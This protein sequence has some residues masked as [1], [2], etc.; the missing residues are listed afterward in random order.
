MA[1]IPGTINRDTLDGL[2]ESVIIQGLDE[3]DLIRGHGGNNVIQGHEGNDDLFDGEGNDIFQGD[4]GDNTIE[5]GSG[6][7]TI[8]VE[9]GEGSD[10]VF[11]FQLDS[12]NFMR[13]NADEL[14]FEQYN[15][16]AN[17]V[18]ANTDLLASVDGTQVSTFT[19]N[20][21]T[22]FIDGY[23]LTRNARFRDDFWIEG[24][25]PDQKIRVNLNG[26][27]DPYLQLINAT[28]GEVTTYLDNLVIYGFWSKTSTDGFDGNEIDVVILDLIKN[29]QEEFH[30]KIIFSRKKITTI[31]YCLQN[32]FFLEGENSSFRSCSE[33]KNYLHLVSWY[34]YSHYEKIRLNW[35]KYFPILNLTLN[36]WIK[37][38]LSTCAYEFSINDYPGLLALQN[39]SIS[40]SFGEFEQ[41]N[42]G[43]STH[44]KIKTLPCNLRHS[45]A[46]TATAKMERE[47]SQENSKILNQLVQEYVKLSRILDPSEEEE[48]RL[49][50]ILE[51][52]ESDDELSKLIS[53][54]DH[55]IYQE[56]TLAEDDCKSK[57]NSGHTLLANT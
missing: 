44:S 17:I 52:A 15:E 56:L 28:T 5:L 11:N 14:G 41:P 3:N 32:K 23:N 4:S 46:E 13:V 38:I 9:T 25:T 7:N 20:L 33:S 47:K 35:K 45:S 50:A 18:S 49:M 1:I 42:R 54:A 39:Q 2:A 30:D 21:S 12:T 48:E 51:L 40:G 27:F 19:E 22:I 36:H 10:T 37:V 34:L 55:K 16:G 8:S 26:N 57:D 6:N 53:E 24:I 29:F 31:F 43:L